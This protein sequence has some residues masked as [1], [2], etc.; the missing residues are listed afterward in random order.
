MSD[1]EL[2]MVGERSAY[3]SDNL[4]ETP[5]DEEDAEHLDGCYVLTPK[6]TFTCTRC[7]REGGSTGPSELMGAMVTGRF[8][9]DQPTRLLRTRKYSVGSNRK[10][11]NAE[12]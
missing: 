4:Q 11:S 9:S 10:S 5:K 7:R 2:G 12:W 8:K 1:D 6:T 3:Q